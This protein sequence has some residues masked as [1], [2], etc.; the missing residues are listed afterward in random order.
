MNANIKKAKQAIVD[1]FRRDRLYIFGLI[2]GFGIGVFSAESFQ[3]QKN[4]LIYIGGMFLIVLGS[5]LYRSR[6]DLR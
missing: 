5:V 3:S 6:N 1:F 2:S 4:P